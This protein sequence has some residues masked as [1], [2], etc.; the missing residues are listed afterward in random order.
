MTWIL[1]GTIGFC[2][3]KATR[4]CI[5]YDAVDLTDPARRKD[6]TNGCLALIVVKQKGQI[7]HREAKRRVKCR[8]NQGCCSVGDIKRRHP[9]F[10]SAPGASSGTPGMMRALDEIPHPILDCLFQPLAPSIIHPDTFHRVAR[11]IDDKQL[12]VTPYTGLQ[13]VSYFAR[14]VN[15]FHYPG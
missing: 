8:R 7:V 12:I 10:A 6:G 4:Y 2:A 3:S 15:G 14:G 13:L 11:N 5:W 1:P 9:S